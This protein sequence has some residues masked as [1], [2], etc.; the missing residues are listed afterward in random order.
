MSLMESLKALSRRR[1]EKG[2]M[3]RNKLYRRNWALIIMFSMQAIKRANKT[4]TKINM[5]HHPL[6][7]YL[8]EQ[9]LDMVPSKITSQ[10]IFK[11]IMTLSLVM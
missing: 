4:L 7:I 8:L 2:L 5:A 10:V 6:I 11:T 3:T 9:M 1:K